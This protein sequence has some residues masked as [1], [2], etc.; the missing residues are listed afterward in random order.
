M[1]HVVAGEIAQPVCAISDG[2]VDDRGDVLRRRH[3]LGQLA[4]RR[5]GP[6]K[7]GA[8]A[9]DAAVSGIE[10][11][12]SRV[13]GSVAAAGLDDLHDDVLGREFVGQG[14]GEA[15]Q[16][17]LGRDVYRDGG[18]TDQAASGTDVKDEPLLLFAED[19]HDR[20]YDV[21]DPEHIDVKV[22][23]DAFLGDRFEYPIL[24][25]S[26]VIDNRVE[27][28][29][30]LDGG[31]DRLVDA[32][33]IGHVQAT[34]QYVVASG[35]VSGGRDVSHCG[36]NIPALVGEKLSGRMAETRRRTRDQDSFLVHVIS[37]RYGIRGQNDVT[38]TRLI[39]PSFSAA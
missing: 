2:A 10:L 29:E 24:T 26:G 31:L 7:E 14:L 5:V 30:V 11:R 34:H 20:A 37:L 15:F 35:Q 27:L 28:A 1:L 9:I 38:T 39:E 18:Q 13:E 3:T 36:D 6:L 22:T 8:V 25:V 19:R 17:E 33:R 23:L 16:R 4:Q 12:R 21:H 32:G